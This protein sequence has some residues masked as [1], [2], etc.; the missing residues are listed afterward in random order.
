MVISTI[1]RKLA[2][3][4]VFGTFGMVSTTAISQEGAAT[5]DVQQITIDNVTLNGADFNSV[6]ITS[7]SPLTIE[8]GGGTA[9]RVCDNR[10]AT[11]TGE[12]FGRNG[13]L[14]E[15]E[16][17]M[18]RIAWTYFERNFQEET[19]L[20]NAVGNFPSTTLWDTASYISALVAAYEL[21]LIDKREFDTRTTQLTNTLRNL[22]LFRGEAPNK[23][24][25]T[26]TG[27]MVNYANEAGEIGMSALDIG[28]MLVW[29]RILKERHPHLANS[30]D[31]IPMRWNFC[32]L[33][34][35]DG[36]M[37]GSFV[38][39]DGN[40]RYVQEGRLGY[41]EYAA[42]GFALWGFDVPRALSPEPL[43]YT[44]IY[45]V[46]VPYDGRDPRV[47][48][49]QNYVLTE[50]YILDG[51]ELG[52][53]LPSDRTGDGLTASHGWRAEFAQRIYL[54]QQ[55]RFEQT[56]I[57]TARSEH[58]VDGR[59]YFVY[60]SIFADGYAWN[61]LDPTGEYQPDRAAIA[62]KAA[63]GLWALWETDYTD[64]LF[65][66]VADLYDVERGFYEGLYENGNGFIPL[67]T[68][69]NNGIILAALLYKV[70]GPILQQ[71]S[72]NTQY[73]DT[74]FAG[75]D[76]RDNKCHP[77]QM[78]EVVNCCN[79][80]GVEIPP[81]I[82]LEEFV[83]CRPVPTDG[84]TAAT[85]CGTREHSFPLPEP[86]LVLPQSCSAQQ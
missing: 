23:V 70:Q 19:G 9:A 63:I 17:R 55:R 58:Q 71:T 50:G 35:D 62:A 66:S 53:D 83:F 81:V 48:K 4:V 32:N 29:L 34:S 22:T 60:D 14:T 65:E 24:Y 36:R 40:T 85:D 26:Q 47:F 72:N 41:E 68:A 78:E 18:A 49:N 82:P 10:T 11:A 54:V 38:Q 6:T 44:T 25:H 56:G 86:R 80:A 1:S 3:A 30:V 7:E 5:G 57:I 42:K 43:S 51:L 8:Y 31:N 46:D 74:A 28:R 21:C 67:Q 84:E 27:A 16:Q 33:V 20:V 61:T 45:D 2:A 69:N 59:P 64:L 79:C 75:T 12:H 73:W 15:R 52:W 77:R 13:A 37:F 39:G 76:I